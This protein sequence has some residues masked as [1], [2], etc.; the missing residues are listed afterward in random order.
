MYQVSDI[1]RNIIASIQVFRFHIE[2]TDAELFFG[3]FRWSRRFETMNQYILKIPYGIQMSS[4]RP[5]RR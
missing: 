4:G 2:F 5:C 3:I 1:Q